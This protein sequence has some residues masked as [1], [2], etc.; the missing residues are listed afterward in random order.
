MPCETE[1]CFR[2]RKL[3]GDTGMTFSVVFG[4]KAGKTEG[5]KERQVGCQDFSVRDNMRDSQ[6]DIQNT[7]T[8]RMSQLIV[9]S[10]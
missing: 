7:L 8:A 6:A 5:A 10:R 9:S 4:R 1:M 2:R 3:E